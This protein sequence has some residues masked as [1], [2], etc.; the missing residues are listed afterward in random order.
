LTLGTDDSGE[1]D[2]AFLSRVQRWL[3]VVIAA[4]VL[5]VSAAVVLLRKF[6]TASAVNSFF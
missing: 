3:L 1:R 6:I 2:Q 5:V 4:V